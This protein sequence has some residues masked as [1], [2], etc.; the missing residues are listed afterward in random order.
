MKE[1]R[2]GILIVCIKFSF[3]LQIMR[4][5]VYHDIFKKNKISIPYSPSN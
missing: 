5:W 4:F 1:G 2:Q 3:F